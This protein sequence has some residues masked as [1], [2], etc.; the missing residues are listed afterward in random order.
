[1]SHN[2]TEPWYF[3]FH[4]DND[5]IVNGQDVHHEMMDA[6]A[7]WDNQHF[8]EFG[9]SI[10]LALSKIHIGGQMANGIGGSKSP[11]QNGTS[12]TRFQNGTSS[13]RF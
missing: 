1:M 3:I 6:I 7:Q 9:H 10:G 2:L 4:R 5:L 12:S 13:T 11:A 8:Y